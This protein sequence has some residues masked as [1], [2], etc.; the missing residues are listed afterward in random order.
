MNEDE[1]GYDDEEYDYSVWDPM[2][3]WTEPFLEQRVAHPGLCWFG[4]SCNI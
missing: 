3:E 2:D 1:F 4:C